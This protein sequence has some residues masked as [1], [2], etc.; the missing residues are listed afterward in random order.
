MRKLISHFQKKWQYYLDIYL[1][2]NALIWCAWQGY[3]S[4]KLNGIVFNELS[5]IIQNF[6]LVVLFIIRRPFKAIDKN[7]FHQLIALTA[8]FSG[9]A[10][11][12]QPAATNHTV[13]TISN[14]IML[15]SNLLGIITLFNLGKSF[16]IMIAYR[17]VKSNGLYSIVRHPMYGTDILLR[18]G[19][20]ISHFT[21]LNII[22]FI[23]SLSCYIY[24]AI[25][26][27]KFLLQQEGYKEYKEKVHYRF[28][29]HIF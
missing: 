10:F 15:L 5:F 29:P 16:G 13:L 26:E 28:I 3:H 11:M 6:I 1:A 17:K 21:I 4:I 8:F 25:L 7:Y 27:E 23:L 24:R 2:L 20:I 18:I 12:G 19:Y 9:L 14:S 22:L